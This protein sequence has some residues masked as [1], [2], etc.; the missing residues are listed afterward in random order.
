MKLLNDWAPQGHA[1]L[2]QIAKPAHSLEETN[3]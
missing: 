1:P 2:V 3:A